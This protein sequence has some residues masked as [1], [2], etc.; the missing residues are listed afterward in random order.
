MF[1]NLQVPKGRKPC[2]YTQNLKSTCRGFP[3]GSLV[4][5]VPANT[6][7]WVQSL[8]REDSTRLGAAKAMSHNH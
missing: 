2:H 1:S 7:D 3:G 4:K 5:N 8:I 6:G